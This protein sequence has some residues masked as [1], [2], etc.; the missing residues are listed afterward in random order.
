MFSPL[1]FAGRAVPLIKKVIILEER[2]APGRRI[3]SS[4]VFADR[5]RG[6]PAKRVAFTVV[7]RENPRER[8]RLYGEQS[9]YYIK[10]GAIN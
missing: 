7:G 3:Y 4:S 2:E 5:G 10:K 8:E 1:R 9:R 6:S